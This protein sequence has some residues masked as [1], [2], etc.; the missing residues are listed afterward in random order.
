MPRRGPSTVSVKG[1]KRYT[2]KGEMYCYHRASGTRLHAEFGSPAFF[3][4]LRVAEEKAK[5]QPAAAAGTLAAAIMLYQKHFRWTDLA[6]RSKVDYQ[7]VI[8][9]LEPLGRMPLATIDRA[10]VAGLR[11]KTFAKKKRRFANYVIAVLS[12]IFSVAAERG[13]MKDNP[14]TGIRAIP[15]PKG[16]PKANRAWKQHERDV[17][18]EEA[19]PTLRLPIA[20]GMF[21]GLRQGD[22]VRLPRNAV[23]DGWL[24]ARTN[25]AGVDIAWPIHTE[26]ARI[27]EEAA[28]AERQR[29]EA[30]LKKQPNLVIPEP[31][32]LCVNS[33]GTSWTQDGFQTSFFKLVRRL[34]EEEKIGAGL[35]FHGLR[36]TVGALLKEDGAS[37]EDIAIALGQKTVAMARHYSQEADRRTR[38]TAATLKFD[39][40]KKK[41]APAKPE[42]IAKDGAT[43][44]G[45]GAQ[46]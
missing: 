33:R 39:P 7:R 12:T 14:A 22:V 3:E 19:P 21:A 1:L 46:E 2:S 17:M 11:D 42:A 36:H 44:P 24:V 15:K 5:G 29:R 6:P 26:L 16:A 34:E 23:Q 27:I 20:L 28:E 10:F 43:E 13:L 32:T 18:M 25:K 37:E 8:D 9:Y 31:M 40:L 38:M 35:T 45:K 30:K 41:K 4:E